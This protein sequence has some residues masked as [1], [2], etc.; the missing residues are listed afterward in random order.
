MPEKNDRLTAAETSFKTMLLDQFDL[1]ADFVATLCGM[2]CK[3]AEPL[4]EASAAPKRR[5]AAATSG[6]DATKPKKTRKKSAY[7]VF[8]R[9]MMKTDSIKDLDHKQK[10]GAIAQLWKGLPSDER[11]QYSDLATEENSSSPAEESA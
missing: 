6:S 4:V 10:M 8:V 9:E 2:F 11:V 1:E 5:T 3:A 7:N